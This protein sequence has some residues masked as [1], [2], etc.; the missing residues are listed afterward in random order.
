MLIWRMWLLPLITCSESRLEYLQNAVMKSM[1]PPWL[2]RSI[3]LRKSAS[4]EKH[5]HFH[6]RFWNLLKQFRTI[7]Q[8]LL[9]ELFRAGSRVLSE[10]QYRFWGISEGEIFGLSWKC[11][12]DWLN[13]DKKIIQLQ[14]KRQNVG[15]Q[16]WLLTTKT[17]LWI[18]LTGLEYSATLTFSELVIVGW[19]F[20]FS[21][22][23]LTMMLST[24][25][26]MR[27]SFG[28]SSRTIMNKLKCFI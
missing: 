22:I 14:L 26:T 2:K 13:N 11:A 10:S 19:S 6:V 15:M 18:Y 21:I 8:M 12:E 1:R 3:S 5:G 16:R 25:A 28:R 7:S 24:R 23:V 27:V 9:L 17:L 4:H 20:T